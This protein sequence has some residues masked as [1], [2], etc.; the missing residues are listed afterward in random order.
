[1]VAQ[2]DGD[3]ITKADVQDFQDE[4]KRSLAM[5]KAARAAWKTHCNQEQSNHGLLN[6]PEG[7][8]IA[9]MLT[10]ASTGRDDL[11]FVDQACASLEAIATLIQ[12]DLTAMD[13]GGSPS[14]F[15]MDWWKTP[16]TPPG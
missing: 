11:T 9:R 6:T 5:L 3:P 12:V 16:G 13:N 14:H 7:G 2:M 1:M 15:E 10:H 8:E 4:V